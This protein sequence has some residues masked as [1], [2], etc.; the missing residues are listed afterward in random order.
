MANAQ[1]PPSQCI[2]VVNRAVRMALFV[3]TP[4]VKQEPARYHPTTAPTRAAIVK[5]KVALASRATSSTPTSRAAP[6]APCSVALQ[7]LISVP[8]LSVQDL[9]VPSHQAAHVTWSA[10]LAI[11]PLEFVTRRPKPPPHPAQ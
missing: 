6:S 8:P 9:H 1:R 3:Q 5:P 2:V 4:A 10:T 7:S 11:L